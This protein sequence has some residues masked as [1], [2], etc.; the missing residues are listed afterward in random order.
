MN[1]K[2]NEFKNAIKENSIDKI[3]LLLKDE[4]MI[5]CNEISIFSTQH[6]YANREFEILYLLISDQRTN[7]SYRNNC[8]FRLASK[9]GDI[10]LVKLLL[11]DPRVDPADKRNWAIRKA[12]EKG[13]VNIVKLLLNDPRITANAYNNIAI[14]DAIENGHTGVVSLLWNDQKIKNTLQND[15]LESYNKLIAEEVKDKVKYF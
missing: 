2:K 10:E 14:I 12:S 6:S 5:L 11:N 1:D 4:T 3:K 7:I 8:L 13:H 15:N 9:N